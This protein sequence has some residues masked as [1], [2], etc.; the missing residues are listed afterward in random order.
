MRDLR[1]VGGQRLVVIRTCGDRVHRQVELILPAEFESRLRERI[2]PGL[3]ARMPFGE[4]RGMRGDLVGDH[5]RLHVVAIRQAEVLLRRDVAQH[6]RAVP[7]D[8]RG[9]DR[10][11]DVVVSGCDVGGQRAERVEGRFTA[12]IELLLHVL[13]DEVHG[14]VPRAF[15][16]HL[17][18]V[19][20]GDPVQLTLG[21]QLGELRF[22]I[23][24]RDRAGAKTVAQR[25]RDVVGA[26][27]LADLAEVRVEE[28]LRV[29]RET[30]L[31]QD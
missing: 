8:H 24:V 26:H 12:P 31:R 22:V 16:H 23:G 25:E 3:R 30:P 5:A 28:V 29:M 21:F 27:D 13:F 20:P 18:V 1:T 10:R 9:A 17:H 19:L 6:R 15:V 7:A 11:R 14:N 2:V 4:I